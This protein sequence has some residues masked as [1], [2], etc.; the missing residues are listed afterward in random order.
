MKVSKLHPFKESNWNTS[1]TYDT[2]F[3]PVPNA[4]GV[5]LI[6]ATKYDMIKKT[7]RNKVLYVGSSKN[8][9]SRLKNHKIYNKLFEEYQEKDKSKKFESS[10]I[11]HSV[12]FY[13]IECENYV[14]IEKSL[15]TKYQ[16]RC[17]KQ[18]R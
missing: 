16:A 12:R 14:G 1:Q 2:N 6:V 15:I 8:L 5:Y 18:W 17:N 10:C 4:S 11:F 13:F 7:S 9:H 3:K